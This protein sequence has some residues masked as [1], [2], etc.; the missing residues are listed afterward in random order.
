MCEGG[1]RR[2]HAPWFPSPGQGQPLALDL[3]HPGLAAM[4]LAASGDIM[5][6]SHHGKG[7]GLM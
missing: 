6:E 1:V 2:T 7:S 4:N 3:S 5:G